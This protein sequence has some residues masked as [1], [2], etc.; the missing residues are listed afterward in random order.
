M[1]DRTPNRSKLLDYARRFPNTVYRQLL[2][3]LAARP[4]IGHPCCKNVSRY[5]THCRPF[6]AR[7]LMALKHPRHLGCVDQKRNTMPTEDAYRTA[8][9]LG[10]GMLSEV[11][12]SSVERHFD[13]LVI[14]FIQTTT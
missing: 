8:K 7:M 13:R 2:P 4:F 9:R 6:V 14:W 1:S 11:T 12:I 10:N 5:V 3:V